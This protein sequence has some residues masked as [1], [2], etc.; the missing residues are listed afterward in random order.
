MKKP[1]IST[2]APQLKFEFKEVRK[3]Q[4]LKEVKVISLSKIQSNEL[5]EKILSRKRPS[6]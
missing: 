4:P 6:F 2:T 3:E 1:S 5:N